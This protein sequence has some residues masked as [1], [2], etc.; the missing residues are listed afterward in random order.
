MKT[1][2]LLMTLF[3]IS[4]LATSFGACSDAGPNG[5]QLTNEDAGD[6]GGGN[7]DGTDVGG[8]RH[9]RGLEDDSGN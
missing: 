3:L 4:I 8:S 9:G 7:D 2:K 5:P 1:A 6:D